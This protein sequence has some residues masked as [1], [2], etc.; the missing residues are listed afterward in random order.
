MKIQASSVQ[1]SGIN[2]MGMPV[3]SRDIQGNVR[4]FQECVPFMCGQPSYESADP[5]TQKIILS[6]SQAGY[7]ASLS[8]TDQTCIQSG[9]GC[10]TPT[11]PVPKTTSKVPAKAITPPAAGQA[12]VALTP[13]NIVNPLPSISDALRPE[14]IATCS[15]WQE[16]N[17]AIARN[18]V[19]SVAIAVGIFAF[20]ANQKRR[21]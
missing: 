14:V 21:R 19:V 9:Y 8:C 16:L 3:T 4:T 6:C 2:R 1:A 15:Q 5:A 20:I 18:P 12:P 7:I 17:A 13:Q 10:K 11:A